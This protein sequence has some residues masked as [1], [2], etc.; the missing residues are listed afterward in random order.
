MGHTAE[1]QHFAPA[2]MAP[3]GMTWP[4]AT[5]LSET[6]STSS[7]GSIVARSPTWHSWKASKCLTGRGRSSAEEQHVEHEHDVPQFAN[8]ARL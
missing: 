7:N 8:V 4:W 5:M 2:A 1:W 3:A 6:P